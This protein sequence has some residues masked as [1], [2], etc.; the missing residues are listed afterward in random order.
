MRDIKTFGIIGYGSFGTFV[1]TLLTVLAPHIHVRVYSRRFD[2]D[3]ATFFSLEEV[4]TSDV[5][6]L[7][8]PI[9]TYEEMIKKVVP[10][11][12]AQSVLLDVATVKK[13]TLDA[14]EKHAKGHQYISLHPMF[15]PQSYEKRAQSIEGFR[16]IVCGYTV[17]EDVYQAVREHLSAFGFIVLEMDA[18]THDKLLAETLFLT[19]FVGQIISRAGFKRTPIDTVSFQ[20]L[21]DAVESVWRDD[22]LFRDVFQYNPYCKDVIERLLEARNEITQNIL[23]L[24]ER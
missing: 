23:E 22:A 7:S 13:V 12:G 4:C 3:D 24:Q 8:V 20:F 5:V 2:T 10:H 21:M 19:H 18:D 1:H 14:L 6:L 11:L 16:I 9:H 17:P 15:G